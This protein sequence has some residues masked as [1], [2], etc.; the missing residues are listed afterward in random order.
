MVGKTNGSA[1]GEA[2]QTL[3]AIDPSA[4]RAVRSAWPGGL[5]KRCGYRRAHP[6]KERSSRKLS[7]V[8]VQP[9][10]PFARASSCPTGQRLPSLAIGAPSTRRSGWTRNGQIGALVDLPSLETIDPAHSRRRIASKDGVRSLWR[11]VSSRSLMIDEILAASPSPGLE[12]ATG[13]AR[14][15]G[16]WVS[17]PGPW[18]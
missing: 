7:V 10:T 4:Q 13:R 18:R 11:R 9:L 5:D 6:G 2:G 15:R 16:P 3:A 12:P 14:P 1:I 8:H 17:R